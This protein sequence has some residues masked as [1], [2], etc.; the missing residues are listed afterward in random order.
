[1]A[2]ILALALALAPRP[3]RAA[4]DASIDFRALAQAGALRDV[5][6]GGLDDAAWYAAASTSTLAAAGRVATATNAREILAA[7]LDPTVEDVRVNATLT[8]LGDDAWPRRG[9]ATRRRVTL[10]G[11]CA[12]AARCAIDADGK[13]VASA[14]DG[15]SLTVTALTIK[16][17]ASDFGGAFYLGRG[18]GGATFDDARF[19]G[20]AAR[21]GGAV[22]VASDAS[23]G[24]V[25]F[26]NTTFVACGAT[27]TN[28]RGG[29]AFVAANGPAY[30]KF[31]SCAFEGNAAN[32]LGGGL[33][34]DGGHVVVNECEFRANAATSGGGAALRGGGVISSSAFDGNDATR[35]GGGLHVASPS[36]D[37]VGHRASSVQRSAFTNNTAAV[38]GAG[39]FAYGR[40]KMLANTFSRNALPASA[41]SALDPN[42]YVCTNTSDGG[43]S[44]TPTLAD[45]VYDP[46]AYDPFTPQSSFATVPETTTTTTTYA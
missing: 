38:A 44:M 24:S 35:A 37:V 20:C 22:F 15:G 1:M 12:G 14:I 9:V 19:E 42:Y 11:V 13:S 32:G 43:C 6:S 16:N 27:A 25:T 23:A 28:G 36:D 34:A 30:V 21:E 40:V 5:P 3:A 7:L 8:T 46:A 31:E 26:R 45:N 33:Y 2:R 18:H 10:R 39:A 41:P 29:A 4:V 17:A